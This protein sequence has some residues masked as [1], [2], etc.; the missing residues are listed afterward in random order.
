MESRGNVQSNAPCP[1]RAPSLLGP[2]YPYLRSRDENRVHEIGRLSGLGPDG[3]GFGCC[4]APMG[5]SEPDPCNFRRGFGFQIGSVDAHWTSEKKPFTSFGPA[6]QW[7]QYIHGVTLTPTSPHLLVPY[8]QASSAATA[9][10][11]QPVAQARRSTQVRTRT[12]STHVA[13]PA[14]RPC[15]PPDAAYV[16][17]LRPPCPPLS[18]FNRLPTEGYTQ[19]GKFWVRRRRD[20]ELEGARNT[21]LRQVRAARC[22]TAYVLC[23]DLYYLWCRMIWRSC[24]ER[25]PV[26]PYISERPGLQEY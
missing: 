18:V 6:Q 25:V 11:Q 2:S 26:L 9:H 16:A 14:P 21:K 1:M 15:L 10:Q 20:Q 5:L 8:P 3:G 17:L 4:F 12:A 19:D 13:S 22:V 24:F 23:G 7:I